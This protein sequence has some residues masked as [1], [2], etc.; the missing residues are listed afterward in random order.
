MIE[1]SIINAGENGYTLEVESATP[2][3]PPGATISMEKIPVDGSS[4]V[5]VIEMTGDP[6]VVNLI[7]RGT[8]VRIVPLEVIKG[9][10]NN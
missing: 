8:E 7:R 4:E 2:G 9:T 5:G 6:V 10:L 3:I 1:T